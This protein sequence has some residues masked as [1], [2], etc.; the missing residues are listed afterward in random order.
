MALAA[1]FDR[2]W[3]AID[4][5]AECGNASGYDKATRAI[6]DLAD[7]YALASGGGREVFDSALQCFMKRHSRRTALIRRLID[8]GLWEK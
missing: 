2:H 8:A 4:Q 6:A 5:H 7:A 3:K 1:D